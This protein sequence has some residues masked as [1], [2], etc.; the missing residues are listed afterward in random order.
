LSFFPL[1]A[2]CSVER[3]AFAILTK[4][5]KSLKMQKSQEGEEAKSLF[6]FLAD[7]LVQMSADFRVRRH[8]NICYGSWIA[9]ILN[10]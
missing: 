4:C 3:R 8:D 10:W 5:Q 7:L 2:R 9:E 1:K 6:P